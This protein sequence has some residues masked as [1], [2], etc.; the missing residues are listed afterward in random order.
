M[1]VPIVNPRY[2]ANEAFQSVRMQAL[3][4]RFIDLLSGKPD[5]IL[6]GFPHKQYI[7]SS[8]QYLGVKTIPTAR[9]TGSVA[10][11]H[12]FDRRFRPLKNHTQKRWTNILL[13]AQDNS[14][15][16]IIVYKIWDEYFVEDGHHRVSV[17][18]Y[19]GMAYLEAEVWEYPN[20]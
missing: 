4:S 6:N 10:R 8:K 5:Q 15:P 2:R 13:S 18:N 12:E 3:K 9:I 14:W 17:A 19:L 20:R 16:P 7:H 1:N 11:N